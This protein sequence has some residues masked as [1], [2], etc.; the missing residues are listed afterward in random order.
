MNAAPPEGSGDTEAAAAEP[1][2]V[3][4]AQLSPA[5]L[6]GLIEA[7]VLREGTDYGARE[8]CLRDQGRAGGGAAS[9]RR[10]TDLV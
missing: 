8:V 2:A 3:P 7:F 9:E 10:G 1:L 6:R 5:A 4:H